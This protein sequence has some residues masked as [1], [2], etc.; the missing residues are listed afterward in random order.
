L[1]ESGELRLFEGSAG[2]D[3]GEQL[4]DFVYVDDVCAVNRWLLQHPEVSGIFNVG[5]GQPQSFNDVANAV[6]DWHQK[7]SIRYIPFPEGLKDAYQ[8]YTRA[9]LDGLRQTGCDI[10]FRDVAS[11]VRTYLDTLSG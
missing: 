3:D 2:F 1:I 8:S 6:I 4:R 7:G 9:D 5:S 10:E 11:G